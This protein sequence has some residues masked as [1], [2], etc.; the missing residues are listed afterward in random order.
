[1]SESIRLQSL[2]ELIGKNCSFKYRDFDSNIM[3]DN[4][5]TVAE[6][7]GVG[8]ELETTFPNKL[9]IGILLEPIDK[10]LFDK[11]D[12]ALLGLCGVALEDIIFD[13]GEAVSGIVLGKNKVMHNRRSK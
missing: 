7:I 1:M 13:N 9:K 5:T 6:I 4:N 12:L 11:E 8:I 10:S 2:D 3:D